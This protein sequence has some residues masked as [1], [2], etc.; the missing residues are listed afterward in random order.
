MIDDSIKSDDD[1]D[2][3]DSQS[4]NNKCQDVAT[5]DTTQTM[6][7]DSS[8]SDNSK[9]Q[10]AVTKD[11][12]GIGSSIVQ[13]SSEPSIHRSEYNTNNS[14]SIE[15]ILSRY[16]DTTTTV[17]DRSPKN[18]INNK[19]TKISEARY[20]VRSSLISFVASRQS[21]LFYHPLQYRKV[22]ENQQLLHIRELCTQPHFIDTP[23][24]FYCKYHLE[25]RQHMVPFF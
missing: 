11:T 23:I 5:K 1:K 14:K 9:C 24:G 17:A 8:Q 7:D 4:D 22:A 20:S 13:F 10:D 15:I 18:N 16:S 21:L 6:I 12:L 2:D 3:D 25:D 19:R